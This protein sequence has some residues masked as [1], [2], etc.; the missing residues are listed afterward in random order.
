MG[1]GVGCRSASTFA[2]LARPLQQPIFVWA[3]A[4]A[5]VQVGHLPLR[6]HLHAFKPSA[7]C[8]HWHRYH[9][10]SANPD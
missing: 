7:A 3:A 4:E 6:L 5:V 8:N 10:G 2:G 1:C 9:A